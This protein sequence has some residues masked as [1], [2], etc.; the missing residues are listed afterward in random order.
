MDDVVQYLLLHAHAH[1]SIDTF[2]AA[3]RGGRKS[4]PVHHYHMGGKKTFIFI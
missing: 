3:Q 2:P 4:R 1:H